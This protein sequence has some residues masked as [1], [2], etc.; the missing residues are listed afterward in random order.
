MVLPGHNN[1]KQVWIEVLMAV[2]RQI[3]FL[4]GVTPYSLA[5]RYQL[6]WEYL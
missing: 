5:D 6:F 1:P 4:C 2:T 3:I